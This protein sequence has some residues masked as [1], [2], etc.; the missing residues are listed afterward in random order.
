M[1]NGNIAF[2]EAILINGCGKITGAETERTKLLGKHSD[3]IEINDF[4]ENCIAGT[5]ASYHGRYGWLSTIFRAILRTNFIINFCLS[6]DSRYF[7]LVVLENITHSKELYYTACT[8]ND[9]MNLRKF[10]WMHGL[11]HRNVYLILFTE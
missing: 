10:V 1:I 5:V 9:Y 7:V 8:K 2:P 3:R 6:Y 11:M 4:T